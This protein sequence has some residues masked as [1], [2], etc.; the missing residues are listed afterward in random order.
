MEAVEDR[1]GLSNPG[2]R[3]F[4][5]MGTRVV[6]VLQAMQKYLS[7]AGMA[8]ALVQSSSRTQEE[9]KGRTVTC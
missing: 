6:L 3:T 5:V 8:K 4:V 9:S 2:K 1:Q 7:R